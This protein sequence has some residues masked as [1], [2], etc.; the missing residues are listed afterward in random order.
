[1]RRS[2]HC[3]W[4]WSA[5]AAM[6]LAALAGCAGGRKPTKVEGTV[7]LDGKPVSG[8]TVSFLPLDVGGRPANGRT[9]QDG[10][11]RLTTIEPG[12]GALPGEYKVSV[13]VEPVTRPEAAPAQGMAMMEQRTSRKGPRG[14]RLAALAERKQKVPPSPVPAVYGDPGQTPLRQTV[15]PQG[16]VRLE[17]Q[18]KTS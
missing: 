13:M 14:E 9:D 3:C 7:T 17:L 4:S 10:H 2:K 15:P 12:D 5:C 18:G 16:P 8:A 6:A 11:F 1:M